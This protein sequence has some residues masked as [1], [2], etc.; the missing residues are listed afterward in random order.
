MSN[1]G[2]CTADSCTK[3]IDETNNDKFQSCYWDNAGSYCYNWFDDSSPNG[4]STKIGC[5]EVY[6]PIIVGVIVAAFICIGLCVWQRKRSRDRLNNRLIY[7]NQRPVYQQPNII[8]ANPNP[9]NQ[10]QYNQISQPVVAQ[11]VVPVAPQQ[12]YQYIQPA[13][14]AQLVEAPPAYAPGYQASDPQQE[15]GYTNQ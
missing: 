15:G 5:P 4:T 14:Y 7:N 10:N 3:C 2:G 9:M 13:Q 6:V 8:V 1:Y 11:S 12:Q